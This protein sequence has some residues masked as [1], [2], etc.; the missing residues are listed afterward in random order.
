MLNEEDENNDFKYTTTLST[1]STIV[2]SSS[3]SSSLLFRSA[4]TSTLTRNY[5]RGKQQQQQQSYESQEFKEKDDQTIDKKKNN[6]TSSSSSSS[7]STTSPTTPSSR[8][9][10]EQ[11]QLFE[12]LAKFIIEIK[13]PIVMPN[14]QPYPM[15]QNIIE[16]E[17]EL[18]D[19]RQGAGDEELVPQHQQRQKEIERQVRD[20]LMS[21]QSPFSTLSTKE[22]HQQ[23]NAQFKSFNDFTSILD[24]IRLMPVYYQDPDVM[25]KVFNWFT[26][27]GCQKTEIFNFFLEYFRRFKQYHFSKVN[28]EMK[29]SAKANIDTYNTLLAYYSENML[30]KNVRLTFAEM[31]RL[32]IEYNIVT[33]ILKMK[34]STFPPKRLERLIRELETQFEDEI[35]ES[36]NAMLLH[37][38]LCFLNDTSR[39]L[40]YYSKIKAAQGQP[41]QAT[42]HSLLVGLTALVRFDLVRKYWSEMIGLGIDPDMRTVAAIIRTAAD[43]MDANA[44]I[45]FFRFANKSKPEISVSSHVLGQL[46]QVL[47]FGQKYDQVEEMMMHLEKNQLYTLEIYNSVIWAFSYNRDAST[48]EKI[49]Q[50]LAK[51]FEPTLE[52]FEPLITSAVVVND[53]EL[54]TKYFREMLRCNVHPNERLLNILTRIYLRHGKFKVVYRLEKLIAQNNILSPSS[55]ASVLIFN[56]HNNE[57]RLKHLV[58]KLHKLQPNFK[59]RTLDL[60][61]QESLLMDDYEGALEWLELRMNIS[62][63]LSPYP[64]Y[65][66]I[67][68][69]K[70]RQEEPHTDYW[71]QKLTDYNLKLDHSEIDRYRR[72]FKKLYNPLPLVIDREYDIATDD[73]ILDQQQIPEDDEYMAAAAVEQQQ[74]HQQPTTSSSKSKK[75]SIS[76]ILENITNLQTQLRHEKQGTTSKRD[77]DLKKSAEAIEL[78]EKAN[79]FKNIAQSLRPEEED[80]RLDDEDDDDDDIKIDFRKIVPVTNAADSSLADLIIQSSYSFRLRLIGL[81]KDNQILQAIREF[82][83]K[84][85]SNSNIDVQSYVLMVKVFVEQRDFTNAE[86]FYIKMLDRGYTPGGFITKGIL[87]V[88]QAGGKE[89]MKAFT[90]TIQ[91]YP[92]IQT[93]VPRFDEILLSIEL[94]LKTNVVISIVKHPNAD[95]LVNSALII[96]SLAYSL[97]HR[98]ELELA[99][100]VLQSLLHKKKRISYPT[101]SFFHKCCNEKGIVPKITHELA[102]YY[103]QTI[104]SG[105]QPIPTEIFNS[106][107]LDAYNNGHYQTAYNEFNKRAHEFPQEINN[108]TIRLAV[109]VYSKVYPLGTEFGIGHWLQI[110]KNDL[111]RAA[112]ISRF[113]F[114]SELLNVLYNQGKTDVIMGYANQKN[115]HNI[116]H[117]SD[118]MAIVLKSCPTPQQVIDHALQMRREGCKFLPEHIEIINKANQTVNN[119]IVK[120]FTWKQVVEQNPSFLLPTVRVAIETYFLNNQEEEVSQFDNN[121]SEDQQQDE[122]DDEFEQQQEQQQSY[123]K[124]EQK[125][126]KYF[127]KPQ[128]SGGENNLPIFF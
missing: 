77:G 17:Q 119:D 96:N 46:L 4:S 12:S 82:K 58:S 48:C 94:K 126:Y 86:S 78:E 27:K 120:T 2:S 97:A 128:P 19:S 89:S 124:A 16:F 23:L 95:E 55:F 67:A 31:E 52:T 32:G 105:N 69:H 61:V 68:Y 25:F 3:S 26:E 64:F 51:Q 39:A 70:A 50:S 40:S 47:L 72:H 33:H 42:Y 62:D 15:I 63:Y 88:S 71:F 38:S 107:L 1:S 123:E 57:H 91:N 112:K 109:R 83:I 9:T 49:Y 65:F 53:L 34:D 56:K 73:S 103:M 118:T 76:Q 75:I 43:V 54:C 110:K 102:N 20:S 116:S 80:H 92:N 44:A 24:A 21:G 29:K 99:E 37:S 5:N 66:F 108:N 113:V 85:Q 117:L 81:I 28:H 35:D 122:Q 13:S 59:Y 11:T 45:D 41:S 10:E 8:V 125:R 36:I 114:E 115:F 101:I 74:Q 93:L 127:K 111:L 106:L 22:L 79:L 87:E 121:E 104:Q 14:Y 84:E 60:C 7:S 6:S 18:F 98:G 30:F 90:Q 100:K